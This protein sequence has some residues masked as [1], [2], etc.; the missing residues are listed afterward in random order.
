MIKIEIKRKFRKILGLLGYPRPE[1]IPIREEWRLK[2][3]TQ[4]R[5]EMVRRLNKLKMISGK[6]YSV[7]YYR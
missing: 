4:N 1:G 6:A 5:E 2:E 3:L 7:S